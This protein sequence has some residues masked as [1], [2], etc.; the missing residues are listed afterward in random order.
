MLIS[1]MD[2]HIVICVTRVDIHP[3]H[4]MVNINGLTSTALRG[5]AKEQTQNLSY[6]KRTLAHIFL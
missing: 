4:I 2:R 3:T 5:K 6:P 1:E